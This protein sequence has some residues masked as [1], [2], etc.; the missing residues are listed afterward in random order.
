VD[1]GLAPRDAVALLED[2]DPDNMGGLRTA[3]D[4]VLAKLASGAGHYPRALQI[5]AGLLRDDPMLTPESLSRT[6]GLIGENFVGD[7][8]REAIRRLS[9]DD[10]RMLQVLAVFG[11]PIPLEAIMYTAAAASEQVEEAIGRL[12]RSHHVAFNKSSSHF[13]LHPI[14]RAYAYSRIPLCAEGHGDYCREEL[15]RRAAKYYELQRKPPNQWREIEDLKPQIRQF[16]QLI[17]AK[18]DVAACAVLNEIDAPYLVRWGYA[19]EALSMRNRIDTTKLGGRVREE[20][21]ES[22]GEIYRVI[23]YLTRS[24]QQYERIIGLD[25]VTSSRVRTNAYK[26]LARVQRRMANYDT[27]LTYSYQALDAAT[28]DGDEEQKTDVLSDL[29]TTYWCQGRYATAMPVT[30]EALAIAEQRGWIEKEGYLQWTLGRILLSGGRATEA[31]GH[32]R[33]ALTA[34]RVTESVHGQAVVLEALAEYHLKIGEYSD[35]VAHVRNAFK[36]CRKLGDLRGEGH[37]RFLLAKI[38]I[39]VSDYSATKRYAIEAFVALSEV[40]VPEAEGAG[41]LRDA[42]EAKL[43]GDTYEYYAALLRCAQSPANTGDIAESFKF[44]AEAHDRA[45]AA[46]FSDLARDASAYVSELTLRMELLP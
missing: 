39:K 32:Y 18:L 40:G 20:H 16:H 2:F 31:Y 30:N 9:E 22:L 14:D 19:H 6:E 15:A 43:I 26:Q 42:A 44:A 7:L 35:S 33:K 29:A 27:A 17:V 21:F 38:A 8:V 23:G 4:E 1:G 45:A 36:L 12:V 46:S 25:P 11:E 37:L 41:H 28:A 3:S 34:F 24:T 13:S 5:V 10:L